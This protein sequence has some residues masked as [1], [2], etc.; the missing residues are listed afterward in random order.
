M[1]AWREAKA[2]MKE[3]NRRGAKMANRRGGVA[4]KAKSR[5]ENN[6]GW[7][8]ISG[9]SVSANERKMNN[10]VR[11]H[12][13]KGGIKISGMSKRKLMK[14]GE[15]ENENKRRKLSMA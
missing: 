1:A 3:N 14:C 2:A 10:G 7:Q 5:N 4:A 13:G 8:R 11:R 15:S 12:G 6:G 9:G